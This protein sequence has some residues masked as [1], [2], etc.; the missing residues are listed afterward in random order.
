MYMQLMQLIHVQFEAHTQYN[1]EGKVLTTKYEH[2]IC[3]RHK[4]R[5]D[6]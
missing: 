5:G 1:K 3:F 4:P 6:I 2:E